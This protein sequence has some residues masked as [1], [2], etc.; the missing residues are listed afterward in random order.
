MMAWL[1]GKRV[2]TRTVCVVT[3]GRTSYRLLAPYSDFLT[4]GG[5]EFGRLTDLVLS[6]A[7]KRKEFVSLPTFCRLV[8]AEH[9]PQYDPPTVGE[10]GL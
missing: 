8:I 10:L 7:E 5:D 2:E 3:N 9:R 1:F 4:L 6:L